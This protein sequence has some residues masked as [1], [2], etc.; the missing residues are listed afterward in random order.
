MIQDMKSY[1]WDPQT[2]TFVEITPTN[3]VPYADLV[4]AQKAEE[5]EREAAPGQYL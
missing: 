5:R 1:K 4:E 2:E 3:M